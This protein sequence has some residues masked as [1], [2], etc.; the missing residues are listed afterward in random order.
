MCVCAVQCDLL[1]LHAALLQQGVHHVSMDGIH[2][3]VH[4][5][6]DGH[7][8]RALGPPEVNL[9]M[10]PQ[11]NTSVQQSIRIWFTLQSSFTLSHPHAMMCTI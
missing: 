8:L 10:A 6:V 9:Q 7:Q 3:D 2:M 5:N 1:V 4:V 11:T